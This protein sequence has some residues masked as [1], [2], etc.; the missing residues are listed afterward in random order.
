MVTYKEEVRILS[1]IYGLLHYAERECAEVYA[2]MGSPC[3][4]NVHCTTTAQYSVTR[5][6][7]QKLATMRIKYQKVFLRIL[8]LS[9]SWRNKVIYKYGNLASIRSRCVRSVKVRQSLQTMF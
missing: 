3:M 2:C 8:M 7:S 4:T 5:D 6:K 1:I 9:L